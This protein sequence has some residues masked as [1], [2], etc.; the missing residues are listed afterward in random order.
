MA[1][2]KI[3]HATTRSTSS[4]SMLSAVPEPPQCETPTAENCEAQIIG[5]IMQNPDVFDTVADRLKPEHFYVKYRPAW[6]AALDLADATAYP[7]LPVLQDRLSQIGENELAKELPH[8][9]KAGDLYSGNIDYYVNRVLQ[10]YRDRIMQEAAG[11][12]AGLA[13][14]QSSAED[15]YKALQEATDALT[16]S[17]GVSDGVSWPGLLGLLAQ[18]APDYLIPGFLVERKLHYLYAAPG[19]GKT[20]LGL[21]WLLCLSMGM[22]WLGRQVKE[23]VHTVYIFGEDATGAKLRIL[24]WC[25]EHG[26]SPADLATHFHPIDEPVIMTQPGK[27]DALVRRIR[28]ELGDAPLAMIAYDT[29]STCSGDVDTYTQVGAKAFVNPVQAVNR[30]LGC[31]ALVIT[32]PGKLDNGILGSA[33][34]GFGADMII[35]IDSADN[36]SGRFSDGALMKIYATKN[37]NDDGSSV[38]YIQ[39]KR[40]EW[41]EGTENGSAHTVSSLVIVAGDASTVQPI[42]D[43][44]GISKAQLAPD[45]IIECLNQAGVKIKAQVIVDY[46]RAKGISRTV[47][48][49]ELSTL[50]TK[51]KVVQDGNYYT[52]SD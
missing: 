15:Y 10:A 6:R 42:S 14:G 3:P 18:P 31:G 49:Q 12:I 22:D 47:M 48:Y 45:A 17:S 39:G 9:V 50:I 30:A 34:F 11:K 40:V 35:K 28:K 27:A 1:T 13:T 29:M 41:L 51:K 5:I 4:G 23:R 2:N 21:D 24:A 16:E 25:K 32:H 36:G 20:F 7:S 8:L 33:E 26:V 52:L 46:C 19:S 37:K 43:G 38:A 44:K